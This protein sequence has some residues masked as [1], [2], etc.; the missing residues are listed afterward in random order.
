MV[1]KSENKI[2]QRIVFPFLK[3]PSEAGIVAHAYNPSTQEEEAGGLQVRGQLGYIV[4]PR[5]KN[6]KEKVLVSIQWDYPSVDARETKNCSANR[7]SPK[8]TE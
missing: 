3:S 4:R 5:F 2:C 7:T 1:K 6:K 8:C